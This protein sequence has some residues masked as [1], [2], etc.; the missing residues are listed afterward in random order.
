MPSEALEAVAHVNEIEIGPGLIEY[1]VDFPLKIMGRN[2]PGFVDTVV[3]IVRRHAPDFD[4]A[5]VELRRSRKKSYL[6]VTCIIRAASREQ[7][8]AL[9]RELSSHPMVTMVL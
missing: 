8:D 1:P 3:G 9:Y 5:T 4:E 6:S 2:A 7:L